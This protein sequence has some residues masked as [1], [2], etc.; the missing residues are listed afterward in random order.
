MKLCDCFDIDG[1]GEFTKEFIKASVLE[2]INENER[3][4]EEISVTM[5]GATIKRTQAILHS[6]I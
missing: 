6:S 3:K 1:T 5:S 4:K 2:A